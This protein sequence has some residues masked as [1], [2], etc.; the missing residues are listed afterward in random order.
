VLHIAGFKAMGLARTDAVF[1]LTVTL[2]AFLAFRSWMLGGG[3]T[4]FWLS[5][6]LSTLTKGPLGLVFA[7]CG[8]LACAWERTSGVPSPLRGSHRVG[9]AR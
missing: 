9:V 1:T 2:T 5:A 4:W 8:L 3:W 7:A 6:A